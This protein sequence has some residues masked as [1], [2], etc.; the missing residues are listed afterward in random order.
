[1]QKSNELMIGFYASCK[2]QRANDQEV[3]QKSQFCIF[4]YKIQINDK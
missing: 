2:L 4:E 1:M 3:Q